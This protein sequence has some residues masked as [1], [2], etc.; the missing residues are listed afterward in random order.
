M[1]TALCII[2][3]GPAGLFAAISAAQSGAE[4]LIVERNT[5]ACRKL[6]RTGRTRCN[7]THS[8]AVRDFIK[9]YGLPLRRASQDAAAGRSGRFLRHS[10]YEFSADDLRQ[11]FSEHGL[12]TKV[13]KDGCVFPATDRAT[14][15]ARVLLG[16]AKESSVRFMYGRGVRTIQKE[17]DSFIVITDK[18]KITAKAVIITTGGLTWPF[19]GSTGDGYS[20]AKSLGHTI[21]EPKA[22]LCPLVTAESWPGKLQGVGIPDVVIK[23]EVASR[24]IS[25]AGPLM[26]TDSGIG[27]PAVF[28][29]SRL[30]TEYL[31]CYDNPVRITIDLLPQY[32]SSRL[33]KEII[34]VCSQHPKKTVTAVLS[35]LVTKAVAA[36]LFRLISTSQSIL[37][38]QLQKTQRSLLVRLLKAMPL[39][40]VAAAPVAEAT[41]THGGISTNEIDPKTMESKL[42]KGLYFAGEVIDVDGPCGGYNLQIAFSTGRLAGLAAAR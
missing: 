8:G 5:S 20:F 18:D 30:I 33:D 34:T 39:S 28:D 27:G 6:L 38:G 32:D 40:V 3:A 13:E 9:A 2:G 15:V 22:A 14:D 37:A 19:T 31:P 11:Y 4:T 29:L 41:I 23:T 26:F 10:L 35:Q 7:L 12:R 21:I 36:Q 25:V 24:K 17:N 1:K 16:H 42:C